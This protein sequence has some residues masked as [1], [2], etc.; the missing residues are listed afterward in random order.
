MTVG[1]KIYR[2]HIKNV[3]STRSILTTN[4]KGFHNRSLEIHEGKKPFV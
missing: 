2:V 3:T 1:R 4:D